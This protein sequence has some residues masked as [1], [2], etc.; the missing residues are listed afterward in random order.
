MF[1][2]IE[3][4][5]KKLSIPTQNGIRFCYTSHLRQRFSPQS[6]TNLGERGS[7]SKY[8]NALYANILRIEQGIA[9]R[10][11]HTVPKKRSGTCEPDGL[12][13]HS[14]TIRCQS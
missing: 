11:P 2:S 8:I 5:G 6:F 13:Y 14:L 9:I 1:G 7:F 12:K 3:L 10:L 4:L